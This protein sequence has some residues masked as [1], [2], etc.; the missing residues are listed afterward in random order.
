MVAQDYRISRQKQ[1]K[2]ALLSHSRASKALENNVFVDE[3]IP[4]EIGGKM[5]NT[6][7]TVRKGVTLESL[8]ALKPVFPD[9]GAG[10]TTAGNASGVGDGA[11]ILVLMSRKVAERENIKVFGKWID[12]V[13]VGVEPRHMGVG[14]VEAIPNLLR[15]LGLSKEDIDIYEVNSLFWILPCL[16]SSATR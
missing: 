15:K 1:D 7:D 14:P 8:S 10:T 11:G 6:D 2:Y 16:P 3:I 13:V 5:F 12:S 4:V 9:W